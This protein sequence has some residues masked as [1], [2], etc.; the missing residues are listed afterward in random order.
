MD[1]PNDS[2]GISDILAWRE[3]PRRM[4]FSMRRH[5]PAGEPPEAVTVST[6]FGS[7]MHDVFEFIGNNDAFDDEAIQYAFD[8]W[9][10]WLEPDDLPRMRENLRVYRQRDYLGVRTVA[11]EGEYRVPLFTAEDGRTIYFRCKIDRLYQSLRDE[12]VFISV[13]Y[14]TSRWPK[15]EEEVHSDPQQ[16]AYNWAIHEVFPEVTTLVNVYDQLR[17]GAIPT[18]KSDAQREQIREWLTRHVKAIMKDEAYGGDG[19]LKPKLNDWCAYCAIAESCS[20][21]KDVTDF[22]AAKIA[23]LAPQH[24]DGR[25]VVVDLDPNRIDEYVSVL[26]EVGRA[27]KLLERYESGVKAVVQNLP[28]D[29][30][31]RLGYAVRER[32]VDT[33]PPRALELAHE[34]MGDAFY[35]AVGLSKAAIERFPDEKG[36]EFLR[37]LAEKKVG[38]TW[39]EKRRGKNAA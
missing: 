14:K 8:K 27:K 22:T 12:G 1:L 2:I 17:Y 21:V 34:V 35:E 15:T 11:V 39:V 9:A 26:E 7:A 37:G 29:H 4:S 5:T 38:A 6:A 31:E 19:L 3:C 10:S 25:S 24:K 18:R 13:D 28:Q 20:I 33:Y 36:R 32:R 16:W 23:A 30:R